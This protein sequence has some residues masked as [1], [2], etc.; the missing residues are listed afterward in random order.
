MLAIGYVKSL[1]L[2]LGDIKLPENISF[3][4]PNDGLLELCNGAQ[5]V[6][7]PSPTRCHLNHIKVGKLVIE[8]PISFNPVDLCTMMQS[9][10]D[11]ISN[12]DFNTDFDY[13]KSL[14]SFLRQWTAKDELRHLELKSDWHQFYLPEVVRLLDA[15]I[16]RQARIKDDE[17]QILLSHQSVSVAEGSATGVVTMNSD[18]VAAVD[19]IHVRFDDRDHPFPIKRELALFRQ[20]DEMMTRSQ[21]LSVV[22]YGATACQARIQAIQACQARIQAIQARIQACQARIQAIQ[23]CIQACQAQIQAIQARIHAF[24]ASHAWF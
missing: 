4:D 11:F 7:L 13:L 22:S 18:G 17:R 8:N 9:K 15:E 5:L 24:Q 12:V 14:N 16:V 20:R 6:I 2:S 19:W 3:N 23:A 10:S 21:F 1:G